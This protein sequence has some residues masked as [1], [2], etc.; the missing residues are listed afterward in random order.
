MRFLRPGETPQ[1]SSALWGCCSSDQG[2]PIVTCPELRAPLQG[3]GV[4]QTGPF[5]LPPLNWGFAA[6]PGRGPWS[7]MGIPL[8]GH[9]GSAQRGAGKSP[10][11]HVPSQPQAG[12][13]A[14]SQRAGVTAG[15][16]THSCPMPLHW[17]CQAQ[18]W[19]CAR[20]GHWPCPQLGA[21]SALVSWTRW[22][23]G[24]G[25][26][27]LKW[28]PGTV[29]CGCGGWHWLGR[30]GRAKSVLL[31]VPSGFYLPPLPCLCC[32]PPPQEPGRNPARPGAG[33]S[34]AVPVPHLSL[35]LK[36]FLPAAKHCL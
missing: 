5:H 28:A 24:E 10:P 11:P 16:V 6:T 20:R 35:S 26:Q 32:S 12:E 36:A 7:L 19:A 13:A 2:H 3:S 27:P 25:L 8:P 23:Q 17:L 34:P 1:S 14:K 30:Q 33:H 31:L 21:A 22:G 15:R 9:L 18:Q 4:S 29:Q